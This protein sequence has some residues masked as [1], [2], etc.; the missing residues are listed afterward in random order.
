MDRREFVLGTGSMLVLSGCVPQNIRN[1]MG[2]SDSGGGAPVIGGSW[3]ENSKIAAGI[4]NSVQSGRPPISAEGVPYAAMAARNDFFKVADTMP[5]KLGFSNA[6][7]FSKALTGYFAATMGARK[8]M[9]VTKGDSARAGTGVNLSPNSY[10]VFT[11]K[12]H[13][14]DQGLPAPG[15]GE[16][17]RM[18]PTADLIPPELQGLWRGVMLKVS[19]PGPDYEAYRWRIQQI[20]W[21]IRS[22]GTESTWAGIEPDQELKRLLNGAYPNGYKVWWDYQRN[23][24]DEA[25]SKAATA[26]MFTRFLGMGDK[27]SA[28]DFT[29]GNHGQR[30]VDASMQRSM[31]TPVTG[32]IVPGS[33]FSL[34]A[35]GVAARTVGTDQLE[36]RIEILNV[37]GKPFIYEPSAWA[38][39]TQRRAQRVAFGGNMQGAKMANLKPYS[40]QQRNDADKEIAGAFFDDMKKKQAERLAEFG[41]AAKVF[42]TLFKAGADFMPVVG[43]ALALYEAT[44]GRDWMT[45]EELAPI[46]RALAMAGTIPG[47]NVLRELGALRGNKLL[48]NLA[49]RASGSLLPALSERTEFARAAADWAFSGTADSV[50]NRVNMEPS[51]QQMTAQASRLFSSFA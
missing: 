47:A 11:E 29:N 48:G 12:G 8:N 20:I 39:E 27:Y 34:I 2:D 13:C 22:A 9:G 10:F 7:D 44:T 37:S 18:V 21:M 38:A 31:S 51:F 15:R 32:Q 40:D 42:R 1:V 50:M 25:R 4:F 49:Q 19:K 35:P 33:E 30:I 17:M 6:V 41:P 36:A 28:N 43:N 24:L 26:N 14:M 45:G 46:N 23:T 3:S 16:L 5:P